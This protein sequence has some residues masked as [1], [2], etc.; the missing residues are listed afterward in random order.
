[1]TIIL[2][3]YL[4][5]SVGVAVMAYLKSY[6]MIEYFFLSLLATP[7]AAYYFLA[8]TDKLR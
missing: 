8:K 5:L 1:M 6:D 4:L 7:F 2:V 3:I